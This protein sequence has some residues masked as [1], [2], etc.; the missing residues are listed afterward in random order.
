[1]SN[2]DLGEQ[3]ISKIAEAG[4][5]SQ[6]DEV[7]E[8]AVDVKA[9][10]V[11]VMQGNVDS[12]QIDGQG[13][14]MKKD[15]RM[16]KMHLKTGEVSINPMSAMF[17]KVELERPTDASVQAVLTEADINRAFNSD[18]I[19]EKLQGLDISVNGT[20]TK[21]NTEHVDFQLPGEGKV[22]LKADV[23]AQG[24]SE[25]QQVAFTAV[26]RVS[27]DQQQIVLEDVSYADGQELSSDLTQALLEQASALLDLR[28]FELEGMHLQVK[29]LD[30]EQGRLKLIGEARVE[31]FPSN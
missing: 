14:T 6:L 11:Q 7:E 17:G 9:N 15:L 13:M 10:P 28:N 31:Q 24:D 21:I 27:P 3:A 25:R 16:E 30:V 8:I 20:P 22:C 26:P 5:I 23:R 12:V 29:Q 19:R 2:G 4:I 18:F 1:V